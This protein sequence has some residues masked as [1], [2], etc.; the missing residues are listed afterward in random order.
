VTGIVY[1]VQ[2]GRTE[3]IERNSPLR[4]ARQPNVDP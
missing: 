2:T 1:D 4:Q 3:V